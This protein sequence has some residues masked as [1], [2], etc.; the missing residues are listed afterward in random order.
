MYKTHST[1][2]RVRSYEVDVEGRVNNAVYVNYLEHSRTTAMQDFGIPFQRWLERGMYIIVTRIDMTIHAPAFMGDELEV[3][4]TPLDLKLVKGAFRQEIMNLTRNNKT[5]T[6]TVY[7]A[8]VNAQGKPLR[9]P[10]EFRKAFMEH[11]G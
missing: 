2:F 6:A 11:G 7:G 8:I 9:I 10:E 4:L 1:R 3:R 5:V